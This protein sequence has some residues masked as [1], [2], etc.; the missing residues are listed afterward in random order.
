MKVLIFFISYLTCYSAIAQIPLT[1]LPVGGNKRAFVGEQVGFTR[2]TI[3]YNRPGVRSR[4]GM[5]WG[6]LIPEGFVNLG[7]SDKPSPWRAGANENTTIEFS[8]PVK[9]EGKDLPAGKYGFFIAYY[10]DSAIL[11]FSK[12][13]KSW[14]SFFYKEE[15]DAL[16]IKVKPQ[17]LNTSVEWLEYKFLNQTE[18]SAVI[19]LV[20]E[21]K[22]IAF[23]IE[24]DYINQQ[25]GIFR[26]E[27]KTEKAAMWQSWNQAAQWC[28]EKNINLPEAL[29]WSDSATAPKMKVDSVFTPWS[30]RSL[31]LEK[32][33]G[34]DDARKIIAEKI[35]L[36]S[37]PEIHNY[38]ML[39][40]KSKRTKEALL[41]LEKNYKNDPDNTVAMTGLVYGHSA[42][43]D[44]KKALLFASKALT[45]A[46]TQTEKTG[47]EIL[48]GKINKGV[49]L[50]E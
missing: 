26:K 15:Q 33:N 28:L 8:L 40:L 12:A 21:T 47:I 1:T 37:M 11:I 32:L 4:E 13:N 45:L 35:P 44:K 24:T 42:N 34:F 14:G 30:I 22:M 25:L 49:S 3:T 17:N 43:N 9:A 46:K 16:R 19:A 31:L 27:L 6:K 36:A 10:P 18:N 38:A 23:R 5:I 48:I 20:W 7:L 39:L 50:I 29:Q 41:L 2:I